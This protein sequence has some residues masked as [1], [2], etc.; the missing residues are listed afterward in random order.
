MAKFSNM[1][2]T[3][4]GKTMYAKTL[5][6]RTIN[7]VEAR[8]GNGTPTGEITSLTGLVNEVSTSA[9][10]DISIS[11]NKAVMTIYVSNENIADKL[12]ITE[13]GLFAEIINEDGSVEDAAMYAY[14]Y[15][16]EGVDIIPPITNGRMDWVM[17]LELYITNATG[18]ETEQGGGTW[19]DE[20]AQHKAEAD[21]KYALKTDVTTT[22]VS[23]STPTSSDG[24]DG[25]VWYVYEA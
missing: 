18:E 16:V 22:H 25:D 3:N 5:Q 21:A 7:F 4:T 20:L 19:Q 12:E 23:T 1:I 13:V 10:R 2:I 15:A 9:I 8:V 6:G 24:K 14:C 17:Q 11:E